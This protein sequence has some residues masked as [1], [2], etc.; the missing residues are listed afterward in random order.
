MICIYNKKVY[1]KKK[2]KFF[3]ILNI[4]I[5]LLIVFSIFSVTNKQSQI[6]LKNKEIEQ[7]KDSIAIQ[8][9]KNNQLKG[10]SEDEKKKLSEEHFRSVAR[11]ELGF[12]NKQERVF[13][14]VSK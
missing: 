13:V 14:N 10:I 1:L 11:K 4:I 5:S 7:L 2:S 6:L 3:L 9:L 8:N 12:V